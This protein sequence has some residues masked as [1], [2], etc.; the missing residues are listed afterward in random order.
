MPILVLVVAT[1]RLLIWVTHRPQPV[2]LKTILPNNV[3][4]Y[5]KGSFGQFCHGHFLKA[6]YLGFDGVV[7]RRNQAGIQAAGTAGGT[8]DGPAQVAPL[9]SVSQPPST[10][11]QID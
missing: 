11:L 10:E 8:H 7:K 1:H 6:E 2:S 9:Q 5:G 3:A 4:M